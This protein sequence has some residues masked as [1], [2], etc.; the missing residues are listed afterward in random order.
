MESNRRVHDPAYPR[1]EAN[2]FSSRLRW[3]F[4]P[5]RHSAGVA[6][7]ARFAPQRRSIASSRRARGQP[8]AAETCPF[9]RVLLATEGSEF[10]SGAERVSIDLAA[11]YGVPLLAVLPLVTNPVYESVAPER[12]DEDEAEAA[13]R[14]E[15]LQQAA[16][17]WGVELCGRVRLGEEPFREVVDEARER[18]ADLIVLRRRGKHSH[19]ANLLLGE[20]VHTVT[21]HTPSDVLI[22]PRGSQLWSQG[23]VL[24][25]DGSPHSERATHIAGAL[26][27]HGGLPLTVVSVAEHHEG[28]KAGERA[29]R[30][31]LEQVLARLRAAGAQAVGWVVGD[32]EPSGAILAAA[33][34]TRA[35][36]IVIGHRGLSPAQRL[37]TGSTPERVAGIANAPV[38]IVQQKVARTA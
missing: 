2:A 38:L 24:E 12:E 10:D 32:G 28:Q 11:S 6:R 7:L 20:M 31:N 4:H 13:A 25:I 22:V 15:R 8:Q 33:E 9:N 17:F 34:Q 3:R 21:A 27:V 23:I 26:A 36:L 37:L 30:A 16:R 1:K 29:A 19:L 35:D 14:I 18:E 5:S